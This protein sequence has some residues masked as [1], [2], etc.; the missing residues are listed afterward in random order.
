[1]SLLK[2]SVNLIA[3]SQIYLLDLVK[4]PLGKPI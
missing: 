1:M 3:Q 4:T 2:S